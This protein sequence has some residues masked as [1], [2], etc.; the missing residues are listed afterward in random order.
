MGELTKYSM[1]KNKIKSWIYEG[2]VKPGEKI[3][4]ENEL[5][6]IFDV[7][8]H[9]IRQAIGDL[10]HEGLLYR[11][12]GSG[13]YCSHRLQLS[14]KGRERNKMI[15]V[16]TTYLSDYIF[17]SIIRGIESSLSSEGYTLVVA[18][19]N[20]DNE[21]EKQCLVNMLDKKIA[22]LIVEPTKTGSFNPNLS[23]Y[24]TLE[25]HHIPYL[26]INQFYQELNPPHFILDDE[27]GGFIATEH[28]IKLGHEKVFGFFKQDDMQGANRMKG[29]I[30][31]FRESG[32]SFYPEMVV[33]YTTENK[34]QKTIAETRK[35]L[36]S[37]DRPTAIFCY[38]DEI[39]LMVLDVVREFGLK[40]PE[41]ISIVG[42]DDSHLS[43]ASE[44]KLTSVT[45]PK[46]QMGIEAAKWM[47]AKVEGRNTDQLEHS[48]V[49]KPE[50]VVR[51][52]TAKLK[53]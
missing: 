41:D 43:E 2:K 27:H 16:M 36:S 11:E 52:S 3:H 22:G 32:L 34:K 33:T 51:H 24:L 23:Y 19:T 25:Q 29:F 1:V 10:V 42:Y 7:S 28:L 15:G 46:M 4:S 17:P 31:A 30:R 49:Y 48:T 40:V 50:L 6:K 20:N 8:R 44:V 9:T 37:S 26:M 12:Q 45:H 53:R 39:A 47:I 21:K 14:E 13:T 18:S 5:M 38:N 35:R